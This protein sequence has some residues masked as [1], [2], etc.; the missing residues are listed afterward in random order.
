MVINGKDQSKVNASLVQWLCT[1]V[2]TVA[3]P[4]EARRDSRLGGYQGVCIA[5][6]TRVVLVVN[7]GSSG[8]RCLSE[9]V[10]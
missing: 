2:K 3:D 5:F 6:L 1:V 9:P 7:G 8:H 10:Q 4:G